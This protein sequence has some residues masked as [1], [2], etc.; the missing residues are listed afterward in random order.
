MKKIVTGIV[1]ILLLMPVVLIF[2]QQKKTQS[3]QASA[4]L[5]YFE[6]SSG[7]LRLVEPDGTERSEEHT[8][9]LQSH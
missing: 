5:E 7:A 2:A 9:E 4:V 8:S 1:F 6:D 3:T